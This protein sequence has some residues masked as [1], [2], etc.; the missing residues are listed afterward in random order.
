M[1]FIL[2][3]ELEFTEQGAGH[4]FR[5]FY[6][7]RVKLLTKESVKRDKRRTFQALIKY[8]DSHLFPAAN[9]GGDRETMDDE[10]R[11]L[12]NALDHDLGDEEEQ[13]EDDGTEM[14]DPGSKEGSPSNSN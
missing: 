3:G 5:R 12:R 8:F 7:T 1:L 10:E 13:V 9:D 14:N 11:E 2:S 4:D 6:D